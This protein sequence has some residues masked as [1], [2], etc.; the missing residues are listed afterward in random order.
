[1]PKPQGTYL[2]TQA[3]TKIAHQAGEADALRQK[4]EAD[5][6]RRD[7]E[8]AAL[9]KASDVERHLAEMLKLAAALKN[10]GKE[11]TN[12][13]GVLVKALVDTVKLIKKFGE[14]QAKIK[15][16]HTE[17]GTPTKSFVSAS[18]KADGAASA[19]NM[20]LVAVALIAF[21]AAV[22]KTA[23]KFGGTS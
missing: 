9:M 5:A 10:F 6:R 7:V 15:T 19:A 17:L 1:M 23:G 16:F 18:S 21:V 22:R 20:L 8:F 12:K 14:L 3:P 4:V 11:P 13:Q 2:R